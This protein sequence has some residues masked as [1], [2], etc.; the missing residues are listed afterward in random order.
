MKTQNDLIKDFTK[1]IRLL[2]IGASGSGK[3]YLAHSFPKTYTINTEP[4]GMDTVA[5]KP[6]LRKNMVGY[7]HYIPILK[8]QKGVIAEGDI[9]Y[10]LKKIKVDL[11]KVRE[12]VDK[13]EVET[14]ILD[15]L[16]YLAE[17]VYTY[18]LE[19]N[20]VLD[21]RG[22]IDKWGAFDKLNI[23]L[24]D[25]VIRYL[26]T[27][28]C[29]VVVTCHEKLES[30]EAMEKKADK[31]SP[32]VP[33]IIGGFRNL[34]PGMFSYV[35]YIAKQKKGDTYKYLART[36]LGSQK[37]A[38]SRIA[39]PEVIENVSYTR[40]MEEIKKCAGSTDNNQVKEG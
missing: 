37:N 24:K 10:Y 14:V 35:F 11:A 31:S 40:I 36:N 1:N 27:L 34:V 8:G 28:P 13:G 12:M 4:G 15:N 17:T 20:P 39:L 23:W 3:T 22:N 33:N 2:V 38:K 7:D 19:V 26:L 30:D 5:G 21:S 16:T 32:V 9:A 18:Y 29:H 6:E 25:F